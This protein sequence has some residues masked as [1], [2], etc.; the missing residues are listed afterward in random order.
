MYLISRLHTV[1]VLF[2]RGGS[3]TSLEWFCPLACTVHRWEALQLSTMGAGTSS[4]RA[5]YG[6]NNCIFNYEF[7]FPPCFPFLIFRMKWLFLISEDELALLPLRV[8][9]SPICL[10][11]SL[12]HQGLSLGLTGT[13]VEVASF[14]SF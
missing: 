3:T 11:W 8:F 4:H 6:E 9:L 12:A 10:H 13:A 14:P 5:T 7:F 1:V 2:C